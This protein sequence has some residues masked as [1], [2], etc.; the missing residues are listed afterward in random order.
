MTFWMNTQEIS[1]LIS[2][3]IINFPML[4]LFNSKLYDLID[5]MKQNII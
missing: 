5:K 1:F 4:I 2:K 3:N